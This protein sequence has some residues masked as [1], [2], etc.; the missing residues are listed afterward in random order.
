MALKYLVNC[1]DQVGPSK[2]LEHKAQSA[3]SERFV[4]DH[5]LVMHAENNDLKFLGL[6]KSVTVS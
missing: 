5:P 3:R 6:S 2:A 1:R 4:H